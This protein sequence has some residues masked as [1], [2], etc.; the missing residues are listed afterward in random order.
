MNYP[1]T[2]RFFGK[3]I[4]TWNKSSFDKNIFQK[5]SKDKQFIKL[6]DVKRNTTFT[7]DYLILKS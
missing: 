1:E 4:E 7:K 5:V 2:T 6:E 3:N